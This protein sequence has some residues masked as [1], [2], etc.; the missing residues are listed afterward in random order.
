M[1]ALKLEASR[2]ASYSVENLGSRFPKYA[3]IDE[4]ERSSEAYLEYSVL[5]TEKAQHGNIQIIDLTHLPKQ[6]I[7]AYLQKM[8]D[9][10]LMRHPNLIQTKDFW[11]ED[12]DLFVL[13]NEISGVRLDHVIREGRLSLKRT[14][15]ITIQVCGLLEYLHEQKIYHTGI[16]PEAIYVDENY[17]VS[18][19]PVYFNR[20]LMDIDPME[21]IGSSAANFAPYKIEENGDSGRSFDIR[22]IGALICFMSTGY[23]PDMV[24]YSR[25]EHYGLDKL[26]LHVVG[27]AVGDEHY[28]LFTKVGEIIDELE[29]VQSSHFTSSSIGEDA[30]KTKMHR[31]KVTQEW[32]LDTS[33]ILQAEIQRDEEEH[34]MRLVRGDANMLNNRYQI[35]DCIEFDAMKSVFNAFDSKLAN[36]QVWIHV[37][38]YNGDAEWSYSFR[39]LAY[40]LFNIQHPNICK[41]YDFALLDE[42]GYISSQRETG[43]CLT[44]FAR[45]HTYSID[46]VKQF[47][48]QVGGA[49][50]T[51]NLQGFQDYLL[52]PET[53]AVYGDSSGGHFYRLLSVGEAQLLELNGEHK[54]FL[55]AVKHP[56]RA[57][58]ELY[59]DKTL[60][61]K[62]TQYILGNILLRL[63][64]RTHPCEGADLQTAKEFHTQDKR[65]IL[66]DYCQGLPKALRNWLAKLLEHDPER[67]FGSPQLMLSSFASAVA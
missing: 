26:M 36:K 63:I 18:V 65:Q 33:K 14:L 5:V 29:E 13:T 19:N 48:E 17:F 61:F 7:G 32:S 12:D 56:E 59:Q 50:A 24:P 43:E 60:G 11:Q 44:H 47:V 54:E 21:Y 66:N 31:M 20:L 2:L 25:W 9:S 8:A 37:F 62:T 64:A 41:V 57:A 45:R 39:K 30:L 22:S 23:T 28:H 3:F 16:S 38:D 51:A 42:V 40:Q 49:L 53:I 46:D 27:R 52:S 58:P 10:R 67:R 4:T 35:S 1:C 34:E 6:K 15:E 55:N